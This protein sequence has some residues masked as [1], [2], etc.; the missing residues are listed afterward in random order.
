MPGHFH[1]NQHHTLEEDF[2]ALE[3]VP[4]IQVHL[5]ELLEL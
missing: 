3:E 4:A 5:Q 2:L 1:Q